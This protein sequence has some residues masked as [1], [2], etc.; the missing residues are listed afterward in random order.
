MQNNAQPFHYNMSLLLK[1]QRSVKTPCTRSNAAASHWR[2]Q[3]PCG[4]CQSLGG[5]PVS[6]VWLLLNCGTVSQYQR[7]L[8]GGVCKLTTVTFLDELQKLKYITVSLLYKNAIEGFGLRAMG[9]LGGRSQSWSCC[10]C[11]SSVSP[12]TVPPLIGPNRR[13]THYGFRTD[14]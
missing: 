8:W 1:K 2:H 13:Q 10:C 14:F 9:A 12:M 5:E 11:F 7:L 6:V 3:R 4:E